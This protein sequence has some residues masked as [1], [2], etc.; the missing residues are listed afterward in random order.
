MTLLFEAEHR[1]LILIGF[2]I[3]GAVSAT[4]FIALPSSSPV[5]FL[6]APLAIL[7]IV[8]FG[9][10]VV[11]LNAYLPSLARSAR[12]VREKAALVERIREGGI[13]DEE[14][15]QSHSGDPSGEGFDP[16]LKKA[17]E[18]YN[19]TLSHTTSRISSRGIAL[20]Y[21]AGI[22][23]L[24][25]ALIPVTIMNGSTFSLRLAVSMSGIWW[26]LFTVCPSLVDFVTF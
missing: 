11:A 22:A 16:N 13:G 23:L 6:V 8:A 18:S 21:A 17:L 2:A 7:A 9:A 14:V 20:G 1:K 4:L 10:S 15:E 3:V 19:V 25:V 5:W 26:G 12:E 24:F